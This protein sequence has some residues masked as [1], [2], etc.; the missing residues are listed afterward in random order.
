MVDLMLFTKLN[1]N[2]NMAILLPNGN[3]LCT[4][5]YQTQVVENEF[6]EKDNS[7]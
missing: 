7:Q 3:V 5:S 2:K 4:F 6:I 1:N